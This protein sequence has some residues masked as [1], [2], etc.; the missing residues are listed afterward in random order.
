[1]LTISTTVQIMHVEDNAD[2]AYLFRMAMERDWPDASLTHMAS[3]LEAIEWL[4][5]NPKSY[6][7]MILLDL[8]MPGISG[9]EVLATL[10]PR[11]EWKNIPVVI[12]TTS[13]DSNDRNQTQ[14]SQVIGYLVKPHN[15]VSF[16]TVVR[17]LKLAWSNGK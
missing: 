17:D 7:D 5:T 15:L 10:Q 1:M 14:Y 16:S 11:H 6:P 8:R 9:H 13:D 4:E 2:H 12:L 3:G